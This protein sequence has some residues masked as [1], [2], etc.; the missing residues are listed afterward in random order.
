MGPIFISQESAKNM[1]CVGQK[2]NKLDKES[3]HMTYSKLK[4][5][6]KKKQTNEAQ[7]GPSSVKPKHVSRDTKTLMAHGM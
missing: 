6:K 7:F 2:L 3:P 4:V 5:K 1:P